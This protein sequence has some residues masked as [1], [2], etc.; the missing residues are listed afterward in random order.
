MPRPAVVTVSEGAAEALPEGI[1]PLVLWVPPDGAEPHIKPV[2]V[3]NMLTKFLR[4]HQREG[5]DHC[6]PIGLWAPSPPRQSCIRTKLFRF[7]HFKS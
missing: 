6:V 1:E 2:I 7:L 3:D 5:C 4:P